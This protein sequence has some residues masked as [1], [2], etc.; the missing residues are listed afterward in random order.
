MKQT[1]KFI[2]T[3][4][5]YSANKLIWNKDALKRKDIEIG[6]YE[7]FYKDQAFEACKRIIERFDKE[8]RA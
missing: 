3:T 2:I 5:D 7:T 8:R 4:P 1:I 6:E